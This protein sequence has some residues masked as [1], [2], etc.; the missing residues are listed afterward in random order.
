MP[1]LRHAVEVQWTARPGRMKPAD[2]VEIVGMLGARM[3][4]ERTGWRDVKALVV[5]VAASGPWQAAAD[6]ADALGVHPSDQEQIFHAT[7][8]EA[9]Q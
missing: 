9:N 6:L 5:L 8:R 1:Q 2:A 3:A 4:K 7:Q